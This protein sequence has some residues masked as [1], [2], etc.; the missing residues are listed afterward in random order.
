M[1]FLKAK[2]DTF[3]RMTVLE[4]KMFCQNP[5]TMLSSYVTI[6]ILL[7]FYSIFLSLP[8]ASLSLSLSLSLSQ[9]FLILAQITYEHSLF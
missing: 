1:T 5:T 3:L 4:K 2:K 8:S 7:W 6:L 9:F